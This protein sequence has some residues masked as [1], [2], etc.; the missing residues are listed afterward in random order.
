VFLP[1]TK[2]FA[3]AMATGLDSDVKS[4]SH[5]QPDAS[6]HAGFFVHRMRKGSRTIRGICPGSLRF[7]PD[8]PYS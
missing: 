4:T 2:S 8:S 7:S 5:L 6:P 3:N 1:H